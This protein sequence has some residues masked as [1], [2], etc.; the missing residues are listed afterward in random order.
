LDRVQSSRRSRRGF[1]SQFHSYTLGLGF[2][3]CSTESGAR[4]PYLDRIVR[5][6]IVFEGY[7]NLSASLRPRGHGYG[8]A[9]ADV[10][11]V[12]VVSSAEY[13]LAEA[14]S[15]VVLTIMTVEHIPSHGRQRLD[16]HL[17]YRREAGRFEEVG[18][19]DVVAPLAASINWL[20][21]K[22]C[23]IW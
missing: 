15:V 7:S 2:R 19:P 22:R 11:D 17:V 6:A 3:G 1:S 21:D 18:D 9:V 20:E 16:G 13:G 12:V 8:V 10:G 14:I 23:F 5:E 4:V